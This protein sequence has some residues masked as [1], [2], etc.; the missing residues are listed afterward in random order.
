MTNHHPHCEHINASLIDVWRVSL[1]GVSYVTDSHPG[2]LTE[3]ETVTA[4]KMHRE[5]YDHLPEF[6]G[7]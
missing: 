5:I 7:F 1:D 4:E 2:E 3:G 6:S